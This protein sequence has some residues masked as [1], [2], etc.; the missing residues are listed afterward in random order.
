[1]KGGGILQVTARSKRYRFPFGHFVGTRL[2]H[3]A[4]ATTTK[5]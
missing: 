2:R 1:V 3:T 4:Y 5:S